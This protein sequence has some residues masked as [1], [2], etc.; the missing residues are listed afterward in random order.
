MEK[1]TRMTFSEAHDYVEKHNDIL[2]EMYNNAPAIEGDDP[3]EFIGRGFAAFEEYIN[4]NE[5]AVVTDKM[6]KEEKL[7][8]QPVA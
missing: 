8:V 7:R 3:G 6:I 1:I 2:Q 5:R 4:R